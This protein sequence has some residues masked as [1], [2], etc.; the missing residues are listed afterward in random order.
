M[1]QQFN[2]QTNIQRKR[3]LVYQLLSIII[4]VKEKIE[5]STNT[6]NEQ[7]DKDNKETILYT[8]YNIHI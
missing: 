6:S 8:K 3:I 2:F 1:A 5:I 7:I 4:N